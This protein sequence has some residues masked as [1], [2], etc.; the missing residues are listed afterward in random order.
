[1]NLLQKQGF[2]NSL[3]LY[4]GVALGFFNL[5]ILF[6]RVLT[7]E[8]IGFFILMG[9]ISLLYAQFAGL[10][11]G[12]IILKYFP[13]YRS[14]DKRHGG[15]VSF[16]T[17]W[18]LIGFVI[19]TILFVVFKDNIIEYYKNK[20][21]ASLLIKYFYYL[22][23]LSFFTL[24]FSVLENMALTVF[25]NVLSSFL[26]E[27]GLRLFT[28]ASVLLIAIKLID[29]R[30]FLLIY[31]TA[32]LVAVLVLLAYIGKGKHF[33]FSA[34]GTQ[35]LSERKTFLSYGI[36][37]VLSGSSFVMIQ[38]L[39]TL[40]LSLLTKQSFSYVGI[41]GT[42]FAIAVVISLPAK[43]LSRTSLQIISQSWVTNDLAKIG[44]IYYKT[45]V[46]QMLIGCLFFIGLAINKQFII[47]LLHKHDYASYFNVFIVVGVAFLVDMTGGLNGYIMNA[48]KYYRLTTVF[49]VSAV[50]LCVLSNLILIPQMGMMGAA[51]SYLITMFAL[52]FAYWLFIKIKFNLQP[53]AKAHLYILMI[54]TVCLLIGLYLPPLK[55]VYLDMVYRSGIIGVV[56]VFFAYVLKI[57]E[58]INLVFDRILKKA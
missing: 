57:S 42:F 28:T 26:R 31:I 22:I 20:N 39:D 2:F 44:K 40:M 43:A 53:F 3:I 58:D 5:I 19:F 48:S 7:T 6:Q 35:L 13:Y 56:Y 52:N 25:K 55:N 45:S 1:M 30:G 10:G 15:F 47:M 46:V 16:V 29:Y 12:N 18:S 54:F 9:T 33:K 4:A 50:A 51:L 14:E 24:V 36:F 23:P 32:N 8:E 49:I 34:V 41:Y 11:I 37:T 17:V 27:V 21:G 38:N